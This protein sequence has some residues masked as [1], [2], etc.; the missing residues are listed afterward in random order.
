MRQRSW[1]A[2]AACAPENRTEATADLDWFS[3]DTSEKYECRA[4]CAGCDVRRECLQFALGNKMVH[5]IWGGVD[6]YEIRRAMSMDA[7]GEP[8]QRDRPPRCPY[9]LKRTLDISG[10]K[11]SRGYFTIC[12]NCELSWYMATIPQKLKTRRVA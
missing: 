3:K 2:S 6:D 1:E 10:S 5:G 11:T 4:I 7:L 9:C 12:T 8:M